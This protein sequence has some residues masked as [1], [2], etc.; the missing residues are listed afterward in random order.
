MRCRSFLVA[1]ILSALTAIPATLALAAS[2]KDITL[3][4]SDLP[5]GFHQTTAQSVSNA[6]MAQKT[7]VPKAQFDQHGRITGYDTDYTTAAAA[8]SKAYAAVG[9]KAYTYKTAS[10]AHWDY[11]S[12]VA[13]DAAQ[14]KRVAAARVGQESTALTAVQKSGKTSYTFEL[15]IFRRGATDMTV[16]VIAAAGHVT[17]NDALH[18]A[19]IVDARASH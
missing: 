2:A 7:G 15:I 9:S 1:A 13:A 18:Y 3:R 19:R 14:G 5:A 4:P 11:T 6:Q 12:A 8:G 17:I 16:V 10:G